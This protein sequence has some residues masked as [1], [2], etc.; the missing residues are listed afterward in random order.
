L[1]KPVIYTCKKSVFEDRTQGTRTSM[2]TT[3][4]VSPGKR[5]TYLT[6]HAY[7]PGE[8][9]LPTGFGK[10]Q[11]GRHEVHQEHHGERENLLKFDGRP[12]FPERIAYTVP[13]KLSDTEA[14]LCKEV[15]D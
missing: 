13:Y 15:T 4:F 8:P 14:R 12:L 1:K 6:R 10:S 3:T 2:P 7:A 5:G 9:H 11:D